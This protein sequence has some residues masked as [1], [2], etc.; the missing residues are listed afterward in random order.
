MSTPGIAGRLYLFDQQGLP[1]AGDGGVTIELYDDS[2]VAK[3]GEAKLLELWKL[4]KEILRSLLQRDMI[5]W[6]YSLLLPWGTYS[7]AIAAVHMKVRY[8][9]PKDSGFLRGDYTSPAGKG[10][11]KFAPGAPGGRLAR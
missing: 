7:P 4:D 11:R 3:G 10:G 1:V 8:D 9:P 2:A 6:G 5:G